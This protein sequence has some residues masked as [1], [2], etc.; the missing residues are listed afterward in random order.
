M[1]SVLA[2]D[3]CDEPMISK[4]GGPSIADPCTCSATAGYFDEEV[5]ILSNN[6]GEAWR[7]LSVDGLVDPNDFPNEFSAGDLFTDHGD[8]TY[9]LVGMHASGVGYNIVAISDFYPDEE[10]MVSN[11]CYLPEL[12]DVGVDTRVCSNEPLGITLS[13]ASATALADRFEVSNIDV[14][15]AV[16]IEGIREGMSSASPDLLT[17][18]AFEYAGTGSTTVEITVIPYNADDC[19]GPP[20]MVSVQ[21]ENCVKPV[22]EL[23][24]MNLRMILIYLMVVVS[25]GLFTVLRLGRTVGAN[26]FAPTE[27]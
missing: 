9:S 21:V 16:Q 10:L 27:R 26:E 7:I 24:V 25:A 18:M 19:A 4:E 17:D 15:D 2:S 22:A 3:A 8:G 13:N 5:L 20:L 12:A 14:G 11:L 23:P 1:V 6:P